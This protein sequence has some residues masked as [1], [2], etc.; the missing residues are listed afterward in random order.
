MPI[1]Q[2]DYVPILKWR[3][4]E[5]QALWRLSEMIKDH[6][7]PMIEVT[8]P[9]FDFETR[10]PTKTIDEHLGD[11]ALRLQKKWGSRLALL[12]CS[13]LDPNVRMYGGK[14]P[15]LY[16][17]E[18]LFVQNATI[19]PVVKI[20][21]DVAYRAAVAS[22]H[23]LMQTGVALRCSL[24]EVI[25]GSVFDATVRALLQQLGTTLEDCDVI[26][27]LEAPNWDPQNVLVSIVSQAL[28]A[29]HVMARSRSLTIAGTSF[30]ESM[31]EVTG[32]LQFWPRREWT[33]YRAIL[34]CL[35]ADDRVPSFGD[36][37]IA[38]HGFAQGDMRLLKPA[39]TIRYACDDGWI[40]AKGANVRDNGFGQ[41][42]GCSGNV[43]SSPFY[44]GAGYSPG[45]AYIEDCRSGTASTGNL[46]TWRWVG[47]NHH[48]TKVVSDLAMLIGP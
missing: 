19:V 11:F 16:L 31:G 48:I 20:T 46:S 47:T 4:G 14:H 34:A 42:R 22:A 12:D 36:Y 35:S 44:L 43:T 21:S 30:P 38:G 27:D 18:N 40:I 41:Y 15:M 37:A 2:S 25:D 24:T 13:L 7:V 28:K 8:P 26:L 5:Y 39:A 6:T 3:Q 9:D 1:T 23:S 45:S 17:C 32:P 33:F 10:T 29:S